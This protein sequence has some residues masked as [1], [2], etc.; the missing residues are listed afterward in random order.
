MTM[1]KVFKSGNSQ[2]IRIPSEFHLAHKEFFVR[3][4]GEALYLIPTS[5][6]WYLLRNTLG[7]AADV[8]LER[9]QP[10]VSEMAEREGF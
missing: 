3:Q 8:E 6:P 5:D 2:A 4:Y 9:D 10:D 1:A 7:K